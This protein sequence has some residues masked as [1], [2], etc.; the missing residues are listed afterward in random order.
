MSKRNILY[1][2]VLGS[3]LFW[4]LRTYNG[5]KSYQYTY[6]NNNIKVV[7]EYDKENKLYK[8]NVH[9][10]I[11]NLKQEYKN[12]RKLVS[13][14]E[15]N[16]N[17][18]KIEGFLDFHE[19][20]KK[21]IY[22]T[23]HT[24][25]EDSKKIDTYKGINI[26]NL[27]KNTYYLWNY[28]GFEVINKTNK[29][30]VNLLSKD[31]YNPEL[32][33]I[34]SDYIFVPNY[35]QEYYFNSYYLVDT[36]NYKAKKKSMKHEYSY[37]LVYIHE[38]KDKIVLYDK[39]EEKEYELEY[40]KGISKYNVGKKYTNKELSTTLNKVEYY[41]VRDNSLIYKLGDY[42]LVIMEDFTGSIVSNKGVEVYFIIKDSLYKFDLNK[43]FSK[44]FSNKEWEFNYKN[45]IYI[46]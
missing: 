16:G 15:I 29:N 10:F 7:E 46:V 41:I 5:E 11:F 40:E 38:E 4:F 45:L 44:I 18:I 36:D 8:F 14:V 43:G 35:D 34:I 42:E 24:L 30:T 23:K 20:C 33:K 12:K 2:I 25:K 31:V 37:E 32:I 27:D 28:K 26:Y 21:K 9:G 6:Y 19:L 22:Y 17:C 3:L 1:I 13:G 39:K